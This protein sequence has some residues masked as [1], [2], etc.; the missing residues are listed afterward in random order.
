V[1][2]K[3]LN[4]GT[5]WWTRVGRDSEDPDRS[6]RDA[7]H[8]NSTGVRCGRKIRR[9]WV[10][11]G[12]LRFNGVVDFD[13]RLPERA[14][15]QTFVCSD[16]TQARG[17]NRLLVRSK[18]AQSSIPDCYLV[19]ISGEVQGSIDFASRVWKSVFSRV[20]A[21]SQLRDMQEA[22]LLMKPGDWIQSS[23]GFWQ[24]SVSHEGRKTVAL[25]RI[26]EP[27]PNLKS[28]S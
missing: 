10:T 8:Y 6:T 23:S 22:M 16:L 17:G 11:P 4:F 18:A 1:L 14:I 26:G 9:H 27:I 20:V 7:A 15:G 19:T 21:A 24:L 2:V 28:A 3:M 5:N 13:P 25:V 12:L